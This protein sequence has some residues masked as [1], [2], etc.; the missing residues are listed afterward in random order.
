[1][2]RVLV[3]LLIIAALA[4]GASWLDVV[5]LGTARCMPLGCEPRATRLAEVCGLVESRQRAANGRQ[6]LFCPARPALRRLGGHGKRSGAV[7][8]REVP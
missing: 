6:G 2:I 8:A 4:V 3:Y 5:V 7:D 1:M